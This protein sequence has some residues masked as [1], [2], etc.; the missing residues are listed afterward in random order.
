MPSPGSFPRKPVAS[1]DELRAL[2][3]EYDDRLRARALSRFNSERPADVETAMERV[4]ARMLQ[5]GS[6]RHPLQEFID[7]VKV[8]LTT[9]ARRRHARLKWL[10]PGEEL[11]DVLIDPVLG[12]IEGQRLSAVMRLPRKARETVLRVARGESAAEIARSEGRAPA[13]VRVR[14]TRARARVLADKLPAFLPFLWPKRWR[15]QWR[16][17]LDSPPAAVL[18]PIIAAAVF[19]T[20]LSVVPPSTLAFP[21]A[22]RVELPV[23]HATSVSSAV[24]PD[25]ANSETGVSIPSPTATLRGAAAETPEDVRLTSFASRGRYVVGIGLGDTCQCRVLMRSDDHGATWVSAAGPPSE[26]TQIALPK[27]YPADPRILGGT[28]ATSPSSPYLADFFGSTWRQM[29]NLPAGRIGVSEDRIYVAA[30]TG[31]WSTDGTQVRQ[32][33]AT[34][35]S[36]LTM[37]VAAVADDGWIWAP[38]GAIPGALSAWTVPVLLHCSDGCAIVTPMPAN[39]GVLGNGFAYTPVSYYEIHGST[40]TA[41]PAPQGSVIIAA[42]PGWIATDREGSYAIDRWINGQWSEVGPDS[43]IRSHGA[44]QLAITDQSVIAALSDAGY[45]CMGKAMIWLPRCPKA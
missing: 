44:L 39:P 4:R 15:Q 17:V 3:A 33:V 43:V 1:A 7:L 23:R 8:D 24:V 37:S 12:R 9:L 29:T 34:P 28:D 6:Y 38:P 36:A 25:R 21:A 45:R 19:N 5:H 41:T 27:D 20:T 42:A 13:V 2:F 35:T 14:L 11:E 32:E 26:V 22:Q 10:L 30:L 16:V 31:V 18:V 40:V